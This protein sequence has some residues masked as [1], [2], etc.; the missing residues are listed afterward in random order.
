MAGSSADTM[1]LS[2]AH[3][4]K[5]TLQNLGNVIGHRSGDDRLLR[6][7]CELRKPLAST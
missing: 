5:R 3:L 7:V 2:I 6:I 1:H 4:V